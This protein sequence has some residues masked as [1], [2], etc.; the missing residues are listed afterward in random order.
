MG[1]ANTQV[2]PYFDIRDSLFDIRYFQMSHH[3]L[4]TPRAMKMEGGYLT[5]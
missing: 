4:R 5:F 1:R 2:R 3:V